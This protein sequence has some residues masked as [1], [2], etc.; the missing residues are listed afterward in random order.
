MKNNKG[1]VPIVI[2]IVAIIIIGGGIY[3]SKNKK[4]EAPAAETQNN[5]SDWQTYNGTD[6]S[7][8]YPRSW[9]VNSSKGPDYG[10]TSITNYDEQN[11]PFDT[12]YIR[13]KIYI[14]DKDET[15]SGINNNVLGL[16]DKKNIVVDGT[17]AVRGKISFYQGGEMAEAVLMTHN[18]KGYGVQYESNSS[19]LI[20][21]FD[22]ILSTFKFTK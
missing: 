19:K 13:I 17:Q 9:Y 3:L 15:E 22:Q 14:T 7:F 8:K 5:T 16:S 18:G 6:Y 4:A 21:A 1:F 20:N 2:I 10:L 11:G 12:E